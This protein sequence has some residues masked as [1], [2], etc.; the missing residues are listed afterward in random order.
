MKRAAQ[1][2]LMFALL[3]GV[4][5]A[6]AQTTPGLPDPLLPPVQTGSGAADGS[7]RTLIPS[8]IALR[9]PTAPL[10]FDINPGNFPPA[11]YPARYL[12]APQEFS[13][14][15]SA[16]TPWTVQL[17]VHSALDAQGQA[18]PTDRLSYRVNGGPW[19]KA[20]GVPQ[21]VMSGVG[22]TPGWT[23]LRIEVALD[24]QGGETGGDYDFDLTFTALVLP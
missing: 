5:A 19:I 7:V 23:P 1:F 11:Q 21:V 10:S 20:L 24:L 9:R 6:T 16:S 12:S 22:A 2:G 15:S 18:I 8:L 17:E 14:F 3:A 13:V 4:G